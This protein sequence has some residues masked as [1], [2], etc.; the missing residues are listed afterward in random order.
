MLRIKEDL[1]WK[2]SLTTNR[3]A[4]ARKPERPQMIARNRM[5][6]ASGFAWVA[7]EP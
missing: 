6:R 1:M 3:L 4:V 5:N 2:S 7:R